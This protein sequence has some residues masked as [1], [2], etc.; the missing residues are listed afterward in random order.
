MVTA[1]GGNDPRTSGTPSALI[2]TVALPAFDAIV[3][4]DG[5]RDR[6]HRRIVD[7]AVKL[8]QPSVVCSTPNFAIGSDARRS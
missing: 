3:Q 2:A 7:R 4:I 1:A 5:H 6:A 8:A